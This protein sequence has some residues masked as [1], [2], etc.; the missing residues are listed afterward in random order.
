QP[1]LNIHREINID[2]SIY[3]TGLQMRRVVLRHR[4]DHAA[5]RSADAET[6]A[7]PSIAA[8]LDN[9]SAIRRRAV[10]CSAHALEHHTTVHRG[11][12][13][14][15]IYIRHGDTAVLRLDRKISASRHEH[16]VTN[17]PVIIFAT[18]RTTRKDLRAAGFDPDLPAQR[19]GFVS[20]R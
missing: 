16:F 14:A 6:L 12:I 7:V 5:V 4:H 2:A 8:Q 19:S 10:D 11:E 17:A 9:Q 18:L 13:D 3:G 15:T 1:S 20:S